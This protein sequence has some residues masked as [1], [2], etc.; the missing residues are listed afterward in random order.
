M[1]LSKSVQSKKMIQ[2]R[3]ISGEEVYERLHRVSPSIQDFKAVFAS[4]GNVPV[5]ILER[6]ISKGI[7]V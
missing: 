5:S 2:R 1:K 6:N 7:M 4:I 3:I